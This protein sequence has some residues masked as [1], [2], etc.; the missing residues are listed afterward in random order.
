M[1]GKLT[2]RLPQCPGLFVTGT[3]TAVGKTVATV[4]LTRHLRKQGVHAT[5]CKPLASDAAQHEGHLHNEDTQAL[6]EA[7]D[8]QWPVELINPVRFAEPLAPGV[9]AAQLGLP[10]SHSAV[11]SAMNLLADASD[12][13]IVEGAGGI[14]VPVDE[15]DMVLDMMRALDWPVLIVCRAGLGTL[16]HTTMTSVIVRQAGLRIAGIIMNHY[17][18][19]ADDV[20]RTDNPRWLQRMTGV[21]ICANLTA[22]GELDMAPGTDL[23]RLAALPRP[24]SDRA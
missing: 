21:P 24:P 22:E 20:S 19:D 17:P 10:V 2:P 12:L 23:T 14:Y 16:N 15:N 18:D 7:N 6:Y 8:R 13:L 9:A 1:F 4:A 5:A 3:D 11:V